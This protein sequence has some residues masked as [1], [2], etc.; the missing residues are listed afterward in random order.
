MA[1]TLLLNWIYYNPVGHA[2]EALKVAKAFHD[3]NPGLEVSVTLSGATP[4]ELGTA[5]PWIKRTYPVFQDQILRDGAKA[6]CLRRIPKAWDYVVTNNLPELDQAGNT[7]LHGEELFMVRFLAIEA[8]IFHARTRRAKYFSRYF[9]A[10][11]RYVRDRKVDLVLPRR[12][13]RFARRYAHP[14]PRLCI[15]LGGSA[16]S[17]YYP[18]VGSWIR[19]IRAL[20]EAIPGSRVFLTGVFQSRRDRTA[21]QAYSREEVRRIVRSFHHVTAAYNI[22]LWNQLELIRQCGVFISPHTGFAFLAPAVGTP[23]LEIAGGDWSGYLF[24]RT[25]FYSVLPDNKRYPYNGQLNID[26]YRMHGKIPCMEPARLEKKIPEIVR[27]AKLLLDPTFTYAKAAR[28]NAR[29][30]ARHRGVPVR[31]IQPMVDAGL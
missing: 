31:T 4:Y 28:Q 7:N 24:N 5:C 22:G 14:G 9:A 29:N 13:L 26:K 6:P 15:L 12:A 17:V 18:A 27:A 21:T 23:W 30:W 25:P 10:G 3:S 16:G 1:K 20:H 8:E 11:L 19:I 2:V